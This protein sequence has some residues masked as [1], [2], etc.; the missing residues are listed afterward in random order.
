[1]FEYYRCMDENIA[2]QFAEG[3]NKTPHEHMG[4]RTYNAAPSCRF[5]VP[6]VFNFERMKGKQRPSGNHPLFQSC[7][8]NWKFSVM[9][10]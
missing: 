2:R 6:T 4:Y 3:V 5:S 1:M 7:C 8:Y 9:S 10:L